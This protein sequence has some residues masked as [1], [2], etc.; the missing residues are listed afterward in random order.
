MFRKIVLLEGRA[1]EP[2]HVFAVRV[3]L[4]IHSRNTTEA[5]QKLLQQ[6]ASIAAN[7]RTNEK[8]MDEHQNKMCLIQI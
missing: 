2:V 4:N 6:P 5:G 3:Q 7:Q 8:I 1:D